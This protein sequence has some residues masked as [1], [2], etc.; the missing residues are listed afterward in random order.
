MVASEA[1]SKGLLGLTLLKHQ[2]HRTLSGFLV[3]DSRPITASWFCVGLSIYCLSLCLSSPIW[4]MGMII[5]RPSL[6]EFHRLNESVEVKCTVQRS[7]RNDSLS[8][9][10]HS[11]PFH[12]ES[13]SQLSRSSGSS[14]SPTRGCLPHLQVVWPP[15]HLA[16][17]EIT[18]SVYFRTCSLP[19][20]PPRRAVIFV[21]L[22]QSA[23]CRHLAPRRHSAINLLSD[24]RKE[25]NGCVV[26][27]QFMDE[28]MAAQ[29]CQ[30]TCPR[31]HSQRLAH[32]Q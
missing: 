31:T 25:R 17:P 26:Q 15:W 21:R 24:Q 8:V 5:T 27:L 10:C 14:P 18:I 11:V 29:R 16:Q 4:E 6:G 9:N 22:G 3:V 23:S 30:R 32:F 28:A 7:Q 19:V 13:P 20:A 2:T 12:T 1:P